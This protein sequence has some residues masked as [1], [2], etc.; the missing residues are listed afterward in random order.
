MCLVNNLWFFE[1]FLVVCTTLLLLAEVNSKQIKRFRGGRI[2]RID[3]LS[4]TAT[5]RSLA[6]PC[7]STRSDEVVSRRQAILVGYCTVGIGVGSDVAV[8]RP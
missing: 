3:A 2:H 5:S 1:C 7:I 8:V 6:L 4:T